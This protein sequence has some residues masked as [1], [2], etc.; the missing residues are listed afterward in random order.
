[1]NATAS[2]KEH[3]NTNAKSF[4]VSKNAE[5]GTGAGVQVLQR[6]SPSKRIGLPNNEMVET[7][8][9]VEEVLWITFAPISAEVGEVF[10]GQQS[11]AYCR[12][13]DTEWKIVMVQPAVQ[14]EV[15]RCRFIPRFWLFT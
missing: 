9:P 14:P 7:V 4:I 5:G 11:C 15:Q 1:M 8:E 6:F 3:K 2:P 12:L 13:L 10:R